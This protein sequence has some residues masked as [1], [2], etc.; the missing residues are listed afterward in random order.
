[1]WQDFINQVFVWV[2]PRS[3]IYRLH[4]PTVAYTPGLS[5]SGFL[6]ARKF[7][8]C[9]NWTM[10]KSA[11]SLLSKSGIINWT[12]SKSACSFNAIR[13]HQTRHQLRCRRKLCS[14]SLIQVSAQECQ[15]SWHL[16]VPPGQIWM[17]NCI[18]LVFLFNPRIVNDLSM[19]GANCRKTKWKCFHH[20]RIL[21]IQ[22][23][24]T[25]NVV[26]SRFSVHSNHT[27]HKEKV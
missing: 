27:W 22:R 9:L 16:L 21:S 12:M 1:M 14:L 4:H 18:R 20:C 19:V 15:R 7:D 17:T 3:D 23:M 8:C 13:P 10:S 6:N 26:V 2:F 25:W 5:W 11:C 24:E